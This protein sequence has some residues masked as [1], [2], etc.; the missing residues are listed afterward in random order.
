ME[1]GLEGCSGGV[2]GVGFLLIAD[3]MVVIYV[4]LLNALARGLGRARLE[5]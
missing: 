1:K 2:V 5:M 4:G 3:R